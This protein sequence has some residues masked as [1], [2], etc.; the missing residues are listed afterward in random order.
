MCGG[1]GAKLVLRKPLYDRFDQVVD[2]DLTTDLRNRS[3]ASMCGEQTDEF[4]SQ[5]QVLAQTMR[6]ATD[7]SYQH[8]PLVR[9]IIHPSFERA[10]I[11]QASPSLFASLPSHSRPKNQL[12]FNPFSARFFQIFSSFPFS[13]LSF[14]VFRPLFI[15]ERAIR[16]LMEEEE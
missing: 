2:S 3:T 7:A 14:I 12:P 16:E 6:D 13:F 10:K 5:T 11:D 1:L 9:S 8:N 15:F 4:N